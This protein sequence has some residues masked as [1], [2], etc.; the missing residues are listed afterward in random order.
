MKEFFVGILV[1]M[2]MAVLSVAGILLLPF[3]L[4]LGIFL[5]VV[6]GFFLLLFTVWAVGKITLLLIHAMS[7]K[8]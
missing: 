7:K 3:L 8:T 2:M 5:R 6:L 4:V 1:L